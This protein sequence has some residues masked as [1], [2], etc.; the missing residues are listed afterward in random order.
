MT[1]EPSGRYLRELLGVPFSEAQLDIATHPLTP[2]L[3]VAGAGSGKTAVLAARVVHLVAWHGVAPGAVLGLT[4][5]NKAAGELADRVRTGLAA[6]GS[7][8]GS[9]THSSTRTAT[10]IGE[11]PYA[12]RPYTGSPYAEPPYSEPADDELPTVTTYHAYAASL[13][14][15]HALRIGRE[16]A[17]QLLTE[18]SRWQLAGRVVRAADGPFVHLDWQTRTV[19][20]YLLDLDA[21][22][23]EHLVTVA[24]VRACDEALL[25]AVTGTPGAPA[26]VRRIA[27]A[28]AAREELLDLVEAYR[29]RKAALDLLDF[30]DQ[31]SIA[32]EIARRCPEVAGMQRERFPVVLLDEYQDTGVAQRVLLSALYGDGHPVTAVGDPCQ[33]I[34]GWRGASVGNLLRFPEHFHRPGGD[35]CRPQ[36]LMTNYRGGER[37]LR[38]A[39]AVSG[40]LRSPAAGARR[41]HLDVPLLHADPA[42]V[43]PGMVVTALHRTVEEEATWVAEQVQRSIAEEQTA[44]GQVAVLCRRRADFPLLHAALADCGLPV[45]VVDLGGLLAMP[46]V[47]DVVATLE[48]LADPTANAALVRLLTGPRWRL[49]ARDLDAPG[50]R[51]AGLA[52]FEAGGPRLLDP[53]NQHVALNP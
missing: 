43:T 45:E 52:A 33:S 28:A 27:A 1:P 53:A 16:P 40:E 26:T 12:E 4:F 18:A 37:L 6:R 20:Q 8:T 32:A 42:T 22:M 21:E 19:V 29:R 15:D 38:V 3:V 51:A 25:S 30:G 14:A 17:T 31:V 5:T 13:V 2:Q 9:S 50:R 48:V 44:P 10:G 41:P 35:R 34:Y 36:F 39:N 24:D 7:S 23:A 49:G 11:P 46:E 47:A